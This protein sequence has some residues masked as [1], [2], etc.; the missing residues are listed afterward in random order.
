MEEGE[1]SALGPFRIRGVLGRGGMG[2][3]YRG[4]HAET[5]ELVAVKTVEVASEHFLSSI[6]RE[7]HALSR[8]RHPGVVRIL[9]QGAANG[10]PWYA[11]E[12][13]QGGTLRTRLQEIWGIADESTGADPDD[14][15]DA[16]TVPA[17]ARR[18]TRAML[19]GDERAAGRALDGEQPALPLAP[20]DALGPT[21]ALLRRLCEALAFLH[22]AGFVHRDLKPENIFIREGDAP[23][24]VD[25]GI[26]ARFGG[27]AGREVLD[28]GGAPAGSCAYM[29]PEQIRGPLVDARSDLYS[30]GTL[31]YECVTGQP[32]FVGLTARDVLIRH[33]TDRPRPPSALR[34]GIPAELDALIL[35]LLEKRPQ[36]RLGYAEDVAAALARIAPA[37]PEEPAALGSQPYLYRPGFLGRQEVLLEL[38]NVLHDARG[39]H[40]GRVFIGGESGVGKT[41]LAMELAAIA[42]WRQF[43]VVTG[44]C[45]ALGV[46]GAGGAGGA[47]G[48]PA[49]PLHALRPLLLAIGDRCRQ[50][51][52]EETARLL[53][54]RAAMLAAYEPTLAG[55]PGQTSRAG[56]LTPL[57]GPAARER[58]IACLKE[59]LLAFAAEQPLLL[60][61]DDLQWADELTLRLLRALSPG[62]LDGRALLVVGLYRL[63]EMGEALR[64]AVRAPGAVTVELSALDDASIHQMACDMLALPRAPRAFLDFLAQESGGNPFFLS[65]YLRAA[66]AEGLLRRDRG[67]DWRIGTFGNAEALRASLPLPRSLAE[68]IGHHLAGLSE[69]GRSLARL[70]A[71]LGREVDEV[72]LRR[73]AGLDE[74]AVMDALVELRRRHILEEGERGW[75][76]FAHDKLREM[77]Y[78]EIPEGDRRALHGRVARAIEG[79]HGGEALVDHLEAL[80]HHYGRSGEIQAAARYAER[81][82]DKAAAAFALDAARRHYHAAIDLLAQLEPRPDVL[83]HRVDVVLK[84]ADACLYEPAPDQVGVLETTRELCA[85]IGHRK[86]GLQCDYWISWIQYALGEHDAS[87]RSAERA[88]A[89]ARALGDERMTSHALLQL[90]QNH[91]SATEYEQAVGYIHEGLAA[92]QRFSGHTRTAVCAYAYGY[93][94][95]IHGD[96]GDFDAAYAQITIALA[97]AAEL[98]RRSLESSVLTQMAMVQAW[99]GS[100]AACAE[101][102]RRTRCAA[103]RVGAPYVLAMSRAAEGLA[104]FQ[105]GDV[106]GGIGLMQKA[107]RWFEETATRLTLS[108]T[109]ACLAEALAL[110]GRPE[111]AAAHAGRALARSASRDRLGAVTAHRALAI[112]AARGAT[113]DLAGARR[114]LAEA[115]ELSR[116][117]RSPRDEALTRLCAGRLLDEAGAPEEARRELSAALAAFQQMGMPWYAAS[118]AARLE[119][120]GDTLRLR[121]A[122]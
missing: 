120:P 64:E 119:L 103:E 8:V 20:M 34:R 113:P 80:A 65:E 96:R 67:G 33:L 115:L 3:V 49:A 106:E 118:A 41:R 48:D 60:I 38:Q 50:R 37:G 86:G 53:G 23:V 78:G 102:A 22:G 97:I 83:G 62:D 16:P 15:G 47:G 122:A 55:L 1:S 82:A 58:V 21:L 32:P 61:L 31:L 109:Q 10:R 54:G 43:Q 89:A 56:P 88:L 2:V 76:R 63:E 39:R 93:L 59:T 116:Q 36:D 14:L 111:E 112:A 117:K 57:P 100:W 73:A 81:A 84:W 108:W 98:R 99:Q 12:L 110:A 29:S 9:A 101:N 114:H 70:A 7:I 66:I 45:V 26:A 68:L 19:R 5:G 69:E 74:V 105:L 107:V 24:L 40:G 79:A 52:P 4:E 104:T 27:A 92:R 94:G 91:A 46:S 77:A 25:F 35:R 30:L 44:E 42:G 95:L 51:G 121:G 71:V 87:I 18:T 17:P 28:L 75:L 72:V 13:L 85:R 90:G 6:R 11:M